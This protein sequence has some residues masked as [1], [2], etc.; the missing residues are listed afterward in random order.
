VRQN[1]D[2][3]RR[4]D[5]MQQHTGQHLLSGIMDKY[6]ASLKTLGWGMG[7][8]SGVEGGGDNNEMNYVELPRKPS[9]EEIELIQN[10][11]NEAIR[12]NLKI[13]VEIPQGERTKV[14][15]LPDD[16]DKQEGVVRVVEIESIGPN[17]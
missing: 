3:Q 17:T 5:H 6:F 8:G 11:C 13:T 14:D 12:D 7:K 1:V 4:W 15:K 16:Y 10:K 2:F 9:A